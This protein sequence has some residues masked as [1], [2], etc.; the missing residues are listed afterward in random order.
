MP[1]GAGLPEAMLLGSV[2]LETDWCR[3]GLGTLEV[4]MGAAVGLAAT[5]GLAA[6]AGLAAPGWG[7]PLDSSR[8]CSSVSCL[9]LRGQDEFDVS[10]PGFPNM[11]NCGSIPAV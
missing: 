5:V 2:L 3:V 8:S 10:P 11:S 1:L 7:R 9:C 6:V 4:E